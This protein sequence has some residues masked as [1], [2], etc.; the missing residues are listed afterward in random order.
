MIWLDALHATVN[1]GHAC[2]LVTISDVQGSAPRAVGARM[3][4]AVNTIADTIGGGVLEQQA[5]D[6][7]RALIQNASPD[8][9]IESQ[10]VVLGAQLSQCCGGKVTLNYEYHP[11]CT[12]NVVVF[13]AGHVAQSIAI[14]LQHLPCR[15]LF[16][17][18][19]DEWLKKLPSNESTYGVIST[20]ALGSNPFLAVEQCPDNAYYLVMTHSHEL[21]FDLIEAILSRGDSAYCGLIASDSKAVRFRS[22]LARKGFTKAEN[23]KLTAPI[24]EQE[25]EG[26]LPMEVA[27]ASISEMLKTRSYRQTRAA[28]LEPSVTQSES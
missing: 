8:S 2:V 9:L 19:R 20:R 24:G 4:V 28:Q 16:I 6:Y 13:G 5:I 12:F 25:C 10:S 7:S 14:I 3:L 22:R 21:D 1:K 11:A 15:A 26:K 23:A 18:S 27:I 17:D